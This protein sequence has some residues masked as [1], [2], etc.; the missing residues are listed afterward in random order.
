MFLAKK[1]IAIARED[2]IEEGREEERA[3]YARGRH[4]TPRLSN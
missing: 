4:Q 3:E 1:R 2:G